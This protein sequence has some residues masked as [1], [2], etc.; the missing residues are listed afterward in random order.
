VLAQLAEVYGRTGQ[1][2][3][4]L[5]LLDEALAVMD[6]TGERWW[7]AEVHRLKGEFLWSAACGVR[8]AALMAE[9]CL[10]QALAVAR[11]QQ[12]RSLELRAAMSLSRLWQQHGKRDDAR[13]LLATVYDWFSEGFDTADL[14]EAK[15]L[16]AELMDSKG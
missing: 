13:Q 16:L 12:A 9:A 2:E 14:R 10:Q 4:G 3:A 8:S 15:A 5:R 6:S 1:T 11:S 7:E